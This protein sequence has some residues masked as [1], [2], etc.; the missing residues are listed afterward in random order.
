[1]TLALDDPDNLLKVDM[2]ARVTIKTGEK[3]EALLIPLSALKTNASGQ[4]VAVLRDGGKTENVPVT[5][6]LSSNEYVEVLDGVQ[7]G[8]KL[9]KVA[10]KFGITLADLKRVNGLN[11]KLKAGP[12]LTL[13]VPARDGVGVA[14]MAALPEQPKTAAAEAPSAGKPLIVKKGENLAAVARR[15]T[16]V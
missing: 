7:A 15:K 6:G 14:E 16:L 1:M 4:Y 9:E 13:L 10:P 12:G 8:D 11:P 5:D 3:N 2:T